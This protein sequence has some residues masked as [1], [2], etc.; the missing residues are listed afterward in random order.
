MISLGHNM[1]PMSKADGLNRSQY[2]WSSRPKIISELNEALNLIIKTC[3]ALTSR[4]NH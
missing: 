4:A 3:F 2:E 1:V